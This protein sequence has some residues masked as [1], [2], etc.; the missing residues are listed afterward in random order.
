MIERRIHK[1]IEEALG[2]QAAVALI[3]PRQVGKTTLAQEI[4]DGRDAIYLDLEDSND[5]EKLT[6]ASLFLKQYEDK[7]VVLDE[8]HCAPEI[9]QTLRGLIDK[10]RRREK[11]T[12]R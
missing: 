3:G 8:I 4:A 11:R 5:R 10:G 2:L 12:G 1:E 6:N 7:L 9:F